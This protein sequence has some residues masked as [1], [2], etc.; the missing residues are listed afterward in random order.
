MISICCPF[1][2]WTRIEDRTE[3]L[4]EVLIPSLNRVDQSDQV[5]LVIL[6]LGNRDI[7]GKGR[8]HDIGEF[9]IRLE[10]KLKIKF[11]LNRSWNCIHP[12]PPEKLW[13]SK[14]QNETIKYISSD[15][16][17]CIG[18]DIE[19]PPNIVDLFN[20]RVRSGLVW[21]VTMAHVDRDRNFINWRDQA[22]GMIGMLKT[23]Y[24]DLGGCDESM[25]RTK[26]DNHFSKMASRSGKL[27]IIKERIEGVNHVQ[28]PRS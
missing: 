10:S 1:Y 8:K 18:I 20:S 4:F 13:L 14:A 7:W 12:G 28:H 6:H 3:E 16:F 24:F 19:V 9:T 17:L 26:Y 15:R 23:D 2:P 27:K 11:M 5:E 22:N 25:I 21:I